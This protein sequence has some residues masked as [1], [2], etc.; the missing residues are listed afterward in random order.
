MQ[1][2]QYFASIQL[3][4]LETQRLINE[5]EKKFANAYAPYS[6][7]LVASALLLEDDTIVFGTN[8]ENAAYPS[9]LCAERLAVFSANSQFPD[10]KIKKVVIIARK[11]HESALTPGASCGAC[12][13]VLLEAEI[14]Q[15]KEFKVIMLAEKNKWVVARSASSLLPLAFTNANLNH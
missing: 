6:K 15:K 1:E 2:F 5:A 7:F 3:L 14:R 10:K 11:N 13:Q 9:G 4:D 12:R 8:Q